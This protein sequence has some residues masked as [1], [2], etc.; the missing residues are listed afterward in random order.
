MK[1]EPIARR[2]G[3]KGEGSVTITT[4]AGGYGQVVVLSAYEVRAAYRTLYSESN[5][6]RKKK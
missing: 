2:R 4:K 3:K 5:R 1:E 6:P